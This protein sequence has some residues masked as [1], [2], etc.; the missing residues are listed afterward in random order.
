MQIA[1]AIYTQWVYISFMKL[2]EYVDTHEIKRASLAE[3]L[4][5]SYETVRRYLAG[6]RIP[7]PRIMH[8]IAKLTDGEVTA[9]DFYPPPIGHQ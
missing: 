3:Q 9:N 1:V 2:N 8:K 7:D 4:G 5:V 6:E